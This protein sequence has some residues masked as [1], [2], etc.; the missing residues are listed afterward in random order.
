MK[1]IFNRRA[2]YDYQLLEKFEAGIALTGPEVKSVRAGHL[3]LEEAFVQIRDN[4]AWLFN[5]HIH[6]YK[7]ARPPAGGYDPQRA[8]KLLLHKNELLKLAQETARR[9]LTIVPVSCYTKG[10]RIKLGIALA[11]GKKKYDKRE[12]L[13]RKDLQREIEGQLRKKGS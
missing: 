10:N 7:F 11:K 8:R 13:K 9:G 1:K 2:R 3:H 12:A 4:E 6:P 5:A